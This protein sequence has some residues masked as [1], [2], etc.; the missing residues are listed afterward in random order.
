MSLN[1]EKKYPSPKKKK[2]TVV[3]NWT[4][5]SKLFLLVFFT[6]KNKIN[7][8]YPELRGPGEITRDFLRESPAENANWTNLM[9]PKYHLTYCGGEKYKVKSQVLSLR[10]LYFFLKEISPEFW[11]SSLLK[12]SK[13]WLSKNAQKFF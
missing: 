13:T 5:F 7:K 4:F 11:I 9:H 8:G 1:Q 12:I 3:G 6:F 10:L 2:P